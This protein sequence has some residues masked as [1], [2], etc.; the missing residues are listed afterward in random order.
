MRSVEEIRAEMLS[1]AQDHSTAS[2]AGVLE[3]QHRLEGWFQGLAW[4]LQE[5]WQNETGG[6]A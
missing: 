6:P 1:V 2:E 3:A 5:P 4:V